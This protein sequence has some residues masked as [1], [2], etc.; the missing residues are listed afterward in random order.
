MLNSW[1]L[2]V[3]LIGLIAI[4]ITALM[5]ARKAKKRQTKKSFKPYANTDVIRNLPE[6]KSAKKKYHL[7]IASVIIT[8]II[9][10]VSVTIV[11]SRPV[12]VTV[13]KPDYANRDIMLC[14]DVSGSMDDYV[15]AILDYF[16]IL[17]KGFKGQRL[18]ITVFDGTSFLASPLTD[19]YA[20]LKITMNNIIQSDYKYSNYLIGGASHIGSGLLGCVNNFDRLGE[21][22]RSRSIILATD[23]FSNDPNITLTQAANYAKRYDIAVYGLSTSDDRS[24]EEIDKLNDGEEGTKREYSVDKE[25]REAMINTGGAYFAFSDV[26]DSSVTK[27]IID[28]IMAQDASRYEGTDALVVK[29]VPIIPTIIALVSISAFVIMAWRLGL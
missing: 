10:I 16:V 6:Y 13:A 15:D 7:I 22:E 14:L 25:F 12:S 24:Q 23:N 9:S 21:A 17:I 27:R 5:R 11:S 20:S 4:I 8:I 3:G 28:Q 1:M 18:G 19:D 26:S 29:D 2:I